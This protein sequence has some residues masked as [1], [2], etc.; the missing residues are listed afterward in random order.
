MLFKSIT[1]LA[2]ASLSQA[3]VLPARQ[4]SD[5]SKCI[6][7]PQR[8]EWRKLEPAQQKGYID[9]VLCLKTKPS[10]IGLKSLFDD[11]PHIHFQLAGS[12]KPAIYLDSYAAKMNASSPQS[13]DVSTLAQVLHQVLL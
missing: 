1:L 2:A 7:P 6:D 12:S 11:F 8:I 5:G 10:R 3:V 13:S 4:V 9:A